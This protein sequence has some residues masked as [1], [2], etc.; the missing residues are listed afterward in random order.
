M[1]LPTNRSCPPSTVIPELAY[2]DVTEAATWLCQAFG[3]VERLR[4]GNHR[5]QLTFGDGAIVVTEQRV[6]PE[7]SSPELTTHT[8]HSVMVRVADA[9]I[10]RARAQ[11]FGAQIINPPADYPYGERQYTAVDLGGHRWTFT[12]T[13]VDIHPKDWGGELFE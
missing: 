9:D 3:F 8:S 13:I 6:V 2:P 10:H 7:S 12:Q 4:I 5:V 11:Q 1:N